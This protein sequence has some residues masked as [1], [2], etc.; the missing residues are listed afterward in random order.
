MKAKRSQGEKIFDFFNIFFL[1]LFGL[2]C[3]YPIIYI[4]AMSFSDS[5]AILEGKVW[6][7]PVGFH[8]DAYKVVFSD[9][10]ILRS[11]LNTI[12]YTVVGTLFNLAMVTCAA[13]PLSKKRMK[14]RSG[15]SLYF[16]FTILFSGGMIPSFLLIQ[17]IGFYN[18]IWAVTVPGAMSVFYMIILRT[19]FEQVP[20]ALEEA[21]IIDGMNDFEIMTKI[22]MPLSKPIYAALT[23]FFAVTHW[24]SFFNAF[25][26]LQ[27]KSKFPLQ[28]ILKEIVIANTMNDL[29]TSAVGS[30]AME[31]TKLLSENLKSATIIVVMLPIMLAYPFVQKHFV[32]GMMIGAVKG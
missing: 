4:T 5:W 23:L 31:A 19:N 26:Y 22:Y 12:L 3:L 2:L 20:D 16:V 28:V 27:S 29:G 9:G 8:L 14:G 21:A 7:F 15:I 30:G 13:Y 6:L 1:S 25:I 32:E 24:N 10:N 18:T 11:Y 17:G